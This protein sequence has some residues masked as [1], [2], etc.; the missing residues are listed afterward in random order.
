M[1]TKTHKSTIDLILT[2]RGNCFQKAKVTETGLSNF[3]KLK[4]FITE[5]IKDL[6]QKSYS[7]TLKIHT[8]VL[9]QMNQTTI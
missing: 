6:M 5:I 4:R 2:N 1:F 7:K 3:Y 9:I 8:S